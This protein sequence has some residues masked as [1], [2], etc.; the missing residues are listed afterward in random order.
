VIEHNPGTLINNLTQ[1]RTSDIA[2]RPIRLLVVAKISPQS[3][4]MPHFGG[5]NQTLL[6]VGAACSG[7]T[8]VYGAE[9]KP[10][11]FFRDLTSEYTILPAVDPI[12]SENKFILPYHRLIATYYA[13]CL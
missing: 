6:Y 11:I 13:Q 3:M 2:P 8:D 10:R 4:V 5:N 12:T 7:G 9:K 1:D